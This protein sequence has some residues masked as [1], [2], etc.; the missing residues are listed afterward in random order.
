MVHNEQVPLTTACIVDAI[1]THTNAAVL[2]Q[3]WQAEHLLYAPALRRWRFSL[4]SVITIEKGG[5]EW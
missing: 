3:Q 5:K 1:A 4:L 2:W